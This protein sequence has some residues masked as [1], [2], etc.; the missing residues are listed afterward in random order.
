MYRFFEN[1]AGNFPE[2]YLIYRPPMR[3]KGRFYI[4]SVLFF[5]K[6]ITLPTFVSRNKADVSATLDMTEKT[7]RH[8]QKGGAG[9]AAVT[10][11]GG[12]DIW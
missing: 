11:L 12:K 7:G 2:N 4:L 8:D 6:R 5:S 9:N 10:E 3:V 1:F